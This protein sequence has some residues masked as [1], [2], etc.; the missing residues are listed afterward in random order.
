MKSKKIGIVILASLIAGIVLPSHLQNSKKS[1]ETPNYEATA[2]VEKIIDGDTLSVKI[3]KI[4]DP[5]KGIEPGI[6][7]LRLAG[8][9]TAELSQNKA[10]EET[11]KVKNMTQKEYE[12]T[13][14]YERAFRAKK[15]LE[16]IIPP[17]T[18]IYLDI[19]DLAFG[20]RSYRGYF[21][22]IIAI[23]YKKKDNE[24][25]NINAKVVNQEYSKGPSSDYPILSKY[26]TEFDP[27]RWLENDYPYL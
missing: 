9:D 3:Q 12:D 19:D 2:T 20:K 5:H 22:R 17:E 14:F 15:I 11:K 4:I 1:L 16:N 24:W 21:D 10:A 7:K 8:I 6:D 23:I 25:I 27:H 18:K 26:N 13:L